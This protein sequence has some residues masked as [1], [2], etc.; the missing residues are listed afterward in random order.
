M[1]W[2]SY[3]KSS[4]RLS[5][6]KKLVKSVILLEHYKESLRSM[7]HSNIFLQVY[8]RSLGLPMHHALALVQPCCLN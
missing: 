4:V 1:Y 6:L 8:Q 5:V 3:K 7:E 2:F